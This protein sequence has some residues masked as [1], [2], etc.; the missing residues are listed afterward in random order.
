MPR[1]SE[2]IDVGEDTMQ[3]RTSVSG[4][5]TLAQVR[6]ERVNKVYQRGGEAVHALADVDLTVAPGAFVAIMGKS[7]S[8]KT[9]LLNVVTGIDRPTSGQIWLG[10]RRIDTLSE[11]QLAILRRERVGLVFQAFN[12]LNNMTALENVILPA[13]LVGRSASAARR[14]ASAQLDALGLGRQQHKLPSQ[15]S[16]GQQQRVAIGRALVNAPDVLCADEPT[17]NLDAQTGTEV[18][19]LLK[20]LH[21]RGLTI[22][23]VTHD[24][25][26]AS[27]A[28]RIITMYD[29]RIVDDVNLDEQRGEPSRAL[30]DVSDLDV[31]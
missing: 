31:D 13:L 27:Q 25:Q 11:A 15:L 2:A 6:L 24:P 12:L 9:T 28:Q 18:L 4:E 8:G 22:I 3:T 14:M 30:A 1:R 26:V 16:G 23:L 21:A 10:D 5:P 19:R 29:G 17:G 20:E 7:G